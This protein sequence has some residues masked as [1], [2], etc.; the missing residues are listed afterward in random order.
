MAKL[1]FTA[2]I[3]RGALAGYA[4]LTLTVFPAWDQ[5]MDLGSFDHHRRHKG[6]VLQWQF[7]LEDKE[8]T[9]YAGE[10]RIM[11]EDFESLSDVYKVARRVLK[12][13]YFYRFHVDF[14][15]HLRSTATQVVFDRRQDRLV[16]QAEI[17]DPEWKVYRDRHEDYSSRGCRFWVTARD[18]DEAK[19][20]LLEKFMEASGNDE[21]WYQ[22]RD[23][24]LMA[25]WIKAGQ[26]VQ[27]ND[28][29]E[30]P[31]WVD[32]DQFFE[33]EAEEQI[34]LGDLV[35]IGET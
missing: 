19:Q 28:F 18:E 1:N 4:H 23:M 34:T 32:L 24:N 33:K 22:E 30:V 31:N 10:T 20:L 29:V 26:P 15:E 2:D 21:N 17:L 11:A 14:L 3:H 25:D 27:H 9:P 6:L 13:Q 5:E 8:R 35:E 12:D 16:G 7:D